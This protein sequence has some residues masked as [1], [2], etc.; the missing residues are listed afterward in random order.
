MCLVPRLILFPILSGKKIEGPLMRTYPDLT[1]W[2]D[3]KIRLTV[4]N[5][6]VEAS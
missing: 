2:S 4:H 3:D 5:R 1:A 6:S